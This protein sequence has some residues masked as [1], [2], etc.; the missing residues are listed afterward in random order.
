LSGAAFED[1]QGHRGTWWDWKPAK[2]VLEDLLDQ[3]VLMCAER[4][5]GFARLYDLTERVLPPEVDTTSPG[6]VAATRHLLER[7][8]ARLGVATAGEMAD[9]F[10]LKPAEQVKPALAGLLADER[11]SAVMVEGW[12]KQ[13]YT[14]QAMLDGPLTVPEH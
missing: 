14:T 2:L 3:G 8:L 12:D 10:R 13:A 6:Q 11:I 9:Y 4:T 1:A 7:G 5:P